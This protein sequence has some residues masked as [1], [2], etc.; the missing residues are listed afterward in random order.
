MSKNNN[1][2]AEREGFEPPIPIKV[3]RF[4]RPVQSTNSATSPNEV[5]LLRL[6]LKHRV[7]FFVT[8]KCEQFYS[9]L[10]SE[11][12]VRTGVEPVAPD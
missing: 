12:V 2:F 7:H 4:S 11:A 5:L 9:V 8:D 10:V 3:C 1:C 6:Y